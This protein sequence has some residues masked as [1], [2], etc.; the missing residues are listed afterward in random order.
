MLGGDTL[1]AFP[2]TGGGEV[3]GLAGGT[4]GAAGGTVAD[5]VREGMGGVV[6]GDGRGGGRLVFGA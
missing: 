6:P 2:R 3:S 1:G 4:D 5:L